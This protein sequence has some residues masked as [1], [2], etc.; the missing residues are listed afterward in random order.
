MLPDS[1]ALHLIDHALLRIDQRRQF[2]QQ[3][4]AHGGQIALALQ[5][6]GEAGEVGLEPVLLGVAVRGQPQVVDHGVD[7]VF[8]LG[9]FAAAST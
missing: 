3:H 5:H 8:Q 9:H 7:V 4:A 6:A 2:G 1:S